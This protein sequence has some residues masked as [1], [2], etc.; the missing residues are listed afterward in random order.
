MR[1]SCTSSPFRVSAPR[2]LS[3]Y[4]LFFTRESFLDVNL[5]VYL[6][7]IVSMGVTLGVVRRS[8]SFDEVPGF[9]RLSGLMALIAVT[10]VIVLAIRKTFI[11]IFFGAS[12]ATLFVL[13]AGLFG[14]LTWGAS[15]LFRGR[16]EPKTRPPAF[17]SV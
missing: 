17:P 16:N 10:F 13:G 7:P 1:C 11:G 3:A 2:S 8:V 9:H 12:L 4:T 5:F 15:A 6:A 14:L